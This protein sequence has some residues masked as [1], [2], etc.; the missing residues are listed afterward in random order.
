[1]KTLST[2]LDQTPAG[3]VAM[4]GHTTPPTGWLSCNGSAVS[5]TTYAKLFAAIGT[6]WGVGDG[7]TTFNIPNYN[8]N[9]PIVPRGKAVTGP[10]AALSYFSGVSISAG[11][12]VYSATILFIIK[13]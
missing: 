12:A 5:R 11:N 2:K 10:A 9:N 7:S 6:T 4:Y 1:M 3:I 8:Q 13:A